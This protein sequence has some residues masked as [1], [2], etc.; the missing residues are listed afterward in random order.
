MSWKWPTPRRWGRRSVCTGTCKNRRGPHTEKF[1]GRSR[2]RLS[3]KLNPGARCWAPCGARGLPCCVDMCVGTAPTACNVQRTGFCSA[4]EINHLLPGNYVSAFTTCGLNHCQAP[5]VTAHVSGEGSGTSLGR[6]FQP[7]WRQ[8]RLH[9]TERP[10]RGQL[11]TIRPPGKG[12]LCCHLWFYAREETSPS[13]NCGSKP[14][15]LP[16]QVD[17]SV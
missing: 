5:Q 4:K 3:C 10:A 2:T 15:I 17:P 7:S 9:D 13:G 1:L 14:L 12:H 8:I 16:L 6:L 11:L